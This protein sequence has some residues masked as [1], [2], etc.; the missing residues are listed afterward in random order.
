MSQIDLLNF[1]PYVSYELQILI[2]AFQKLPQKTRK[3][4]PTRRKRPPTDEDIAF[5]GVEGTFL[6]LVAGL[7]FIIIRSKHGKISIFFH[8]NYDVSI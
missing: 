7:L 5:E 2:I 6:R 4:N 8:T 3:G 1:I